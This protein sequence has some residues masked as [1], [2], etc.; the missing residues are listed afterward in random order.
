M[1][2]RKQLLGA[3]IAALLVTAPI[4]LAGAPIGLA[5]YVEKTSDGNVLTVKLN[6]DASRIK[7]MRIRYTVTCDDGRSGQTYTDIVGAK[8]RKDR[9]FSAHGTYTGSGDGSQNTFQVSGALARN[10][11][12]G[13]FSL[14]A[15]SLASDGS[16]IHCKTG[17]L[18]WS[19]K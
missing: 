10:K 5:K 2:H 14:T 7:R 19:A 6:G 3:A 9:S 18:T 15:T 4:A 16:T 13:K 17:K 8:V 12:S 11:A 1:R